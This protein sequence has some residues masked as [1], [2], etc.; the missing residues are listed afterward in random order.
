MPEKCFAQKCLLA[1]APVDAGWTA[2]GIPRMPGMGPI[3]AVD[4]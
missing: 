1:K 3:S 2:Y 4:E